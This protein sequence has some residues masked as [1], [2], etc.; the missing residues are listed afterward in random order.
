MS[1]LRNTYELKEQIERQYIPDLGKQRI[2]RM[3]ELAGISTDEVHEFLS[4]VE[5]DP[6]A[7]P[8]LITST[9]KEY[10]Q[11]QYSEISEEA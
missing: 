3:I 6:S 2:Q 4:R 9:L 10:I 11:S 7:T 8:D 1:G 5:I